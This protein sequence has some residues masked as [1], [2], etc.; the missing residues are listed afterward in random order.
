[1]SKAS[2]HSFEMGITRL[3]CRRA[4]AGTEMLKDFAKNI[5]PG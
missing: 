4:K 3:I 1:M 5:Y 2:Y